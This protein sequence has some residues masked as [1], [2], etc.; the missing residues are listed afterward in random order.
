M[1]SRMEIRTSFFLLTLVMALVIGFLAGYI[2]TNQVNWNAQRGA[3]AANSADTAGLPPASADTSGRLPEGHPQINPEPVI[4]AMKADAE[5]DPG[6]IEKTARL[7]NFLYDSK[8][9]TEA[10]DW[11]QKALQL[12]P[13]NADIETDLG[14]AYYY[15]NDPDSALLHFNNA[16]R[17][18]PRHIQ[19]LH[20]KF[21]VLLEGKKDTAAARATMKQLETIAPNDA[22]LKELRDMLDRA[23]K[24]P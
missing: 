18:D 14:T 21:I 10:I 8:R 22:S 3:P 1:P 5:K 11:Y 15:T 17:N 9:Y 19:T 13:K 24:R 7:A 4:A 12:D 6:N 16:L 23:E 2:Y 20:N